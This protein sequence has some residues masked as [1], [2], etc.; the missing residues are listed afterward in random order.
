M[1][2]SGLTKAIEKIMQRT[3]Q[4]PCKTDAW[5]NPYI[6]VN[7]YVRGFAIGAIALSVLVLILMPMYNGGLIQR[8]YCATN[9]S[10][11]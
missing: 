5:G 11:L 8:S 6:S 4:M 9:N 3:S 2:N 10:C 1:L 7:K